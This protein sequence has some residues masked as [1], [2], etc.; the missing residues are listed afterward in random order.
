[1]CSFIRIDSGLDQDLVG[2]CTSD[3]V[4][5]GQGNLNPLVSRYVNACNSCH[6]SASLALFLFMLGV[7]ANDPDNSLSLDYLAFVT[8]LFYR[9]FYLHTSLLLNAINNSASCEVIW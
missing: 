6:L 9:R 3:A 5:I 4:N 2:E 8:S 7:L 1:M